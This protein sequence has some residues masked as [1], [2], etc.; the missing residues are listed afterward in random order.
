MRTLTDSCVGLPGPPA[1]TVDFNRERDRPSVH[2]PPSRSGAC[3]IGRCCADNET[4]ATSP[5]RQTHREMGTQS[6]GTSKRSA[7]LPKEPSEGGGEDKEV[8]ACPTPHVPLRLLSRGWCGCLHAWL[9]PSRSS[10]ALPLRKPTTGA[11]AVGIIPPPE[12]IPRAGTTTDLTGGTTRRV[13]AP[14]RAIIRAMALRRAARP[15]PR[16]P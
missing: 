4:S 3:A 8:F 12:L 11:K 16:R 7:G 13:V 15:P 9:S 14:P 2:E 5:K 6:H 1:A 10:R